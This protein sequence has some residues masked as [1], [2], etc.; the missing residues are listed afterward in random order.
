VNLLRS[1]SAI[2]LVCLAAALVS[3]QEGVRRVFVRV[4][5]VNGSPVTSLAAADFHVR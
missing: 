2:V 5:T 4:Q 1:A 3:A